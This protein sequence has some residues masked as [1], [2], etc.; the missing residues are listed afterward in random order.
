MSFGFMEKNRLLLTPKQEADL[1][2]SLKLGKK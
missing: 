2:V 1:K